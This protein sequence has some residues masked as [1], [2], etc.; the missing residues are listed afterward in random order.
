[1]FAVECQSWLNVA[2]IWGKST[3]VNHMHHLTQTTVLQVF[4]PPRLC[5]Q[6]A[7]DFFFFK[8]VVLNASLVIL[9]YSQMPAPNYHVGGNKK[10][11]IIIDMSR[12]RAEIKRTCSGQGWW[13]LNNLKLR[14]YSKY[15]SLW[16]KILLLWA[17]MNG[18]S[19]T[20]ICNEYIRLFQNGLKK[21]F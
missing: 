14:E 9:W 10:R 8:F 4:N 19:F 15:T 18:T 5:L 12:H 1:M 21:D 16:D 3:H 2:R 20:N 7:C 6:C 17:V 11:S 13:P